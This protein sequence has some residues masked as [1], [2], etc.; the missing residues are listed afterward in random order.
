MNLPAC[1]AKIFYPNAQLI[2]SERNTTQILTRNLKILYAL[3]RLANYIAPNSHSQ[4]KYLSDRYPKY[5]YKIRTITNF[6]HVNRFVPA[7][8]N[9]SPYNNII[10]RN[11]NVVK[12]ES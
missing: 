2:V 4:S 12:Y 10:H 3:Y 11:K 6:L 7:A 9:R 8:I 5:K 1:I